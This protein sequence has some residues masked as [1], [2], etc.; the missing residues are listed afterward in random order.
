MPLH[1]CV[2]DAWYQPYIWYTATDNKL[3]IHQ[4]NQKKKLRFFNKYIN[5]KMT[6]QTV[7]IMGG[8]IGGLTVA[9]E[10]SKYPDEYDITIFE[11]NSELGGQARSGE[12][13]DGTHSEY[14]WH[15]VS[16]GYSN[17]PRILK[18]I[19]TNDGRNVLEH[20][21]PFD[22][23]VFETD[24]IHLRDTSGKN[25]LTQPKQFF[26]TLSK[27]TGKNH[28]KDRLR[29]YWLLLKIKFMSKKRLESLDKVLWKDYVSHFSPEFQRWAVDSTS[30]YLGMEYDEISAHLMIDLFRHNWTPDKYLDSNYSFYAFDGPI[31]QV[32]FDPWGKLLES[33]GVKIHLN[34]TVESVKHDSLS[35]NHIVVNGENYEADLFVNGMDIHSV[36]K[37]FECPHFKHLSHQSHQIQTQVLFHLPYRMHERRNSV[38]IY[39]ES[40]W[41]LMSRHEGSLWNL[42]NEDYL[43]CGI[44]MWNVP[45][46]NGKTALECTEKELAEECLL[47]MKLPR[48]DYRWN[49]WHSYQFNDATGQMDTWEPKFSNN[50]NTLWCRPTE[51]DECLSNLFHATAYNRTG[52]NVFNMDSA[53]EGGLLA[54]KAIAK[55][56]DIVIYPVEKNSW[57]VR[58]IRKLF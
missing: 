23:Y 3:V 29:A 14:C 22:N 9:H 40:P 4:S 25:F 58:M 52:M 32:W 7:I 33:R 27:I 16:S 15:A 51:R 26:S 56:K 35:I 11:R 50:I 57:F 49:I 41:F 17:L 5:N 24:K 6:K 2:T 34:S 55:D 20:L 10:L 36:A 37:L 46:V 8:G 39:P 53:A 1:R 45:G 12:M 28:Y 42:E 48:N 54:A 31:N 47:Q 38:F 19:P 13:P 21:K 18:E 30:I 43:S 44:G